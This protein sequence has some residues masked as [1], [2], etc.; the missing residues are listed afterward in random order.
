MHDAEETEVEV[1]TVNQDEENEE[2]VEERSTRVRGLQRELHNMRCDW[3][4]NPE[5]FMD[6]G[7]TEMVDFLDDE[8]AEIV[9]SMIELDKDI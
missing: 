2:E 6:D 4:Q 7:Q 3:N 8:Y 9:F 5:E 1:I